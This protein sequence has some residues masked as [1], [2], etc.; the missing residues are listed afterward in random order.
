[1]RINGIGIAFL[2]AT[3]AADDGTYTA[4]KVVT[5]LYAPI[6]PICKM[7]LKRRITKSNL[8]ELELEVP[9]KMELKSILWIYVKGWIVY[10]MILF[11]PLALSVIEV[12]TAIGLPDNLYNYFFGFALVYLIIVVWILSDRYDTQGLPIEFVKTRKSK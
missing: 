5:F 10:P 4:Y 8:F 1:M 2:N 9:E 3:K 7:R 6:F 11:A 12:Y